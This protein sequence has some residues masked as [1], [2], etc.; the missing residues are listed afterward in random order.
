MI[1]KLEPAK[2]ESKSS[3]VADH[4]A[5]RLDQPGSTSAAVAGASR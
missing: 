5:T 1:K 3:S 2:P 4:P